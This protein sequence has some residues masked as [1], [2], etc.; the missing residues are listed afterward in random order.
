MGKKTEKGKDKSKKARMKEQRKGKKQSKTMGRFLTAT[1][2]E[3]I[4]A[5]NEL[6]DGIILEVY[7]GDGSR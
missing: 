1:A 2:E 4:M 3:L 6:P 7:F 5:I